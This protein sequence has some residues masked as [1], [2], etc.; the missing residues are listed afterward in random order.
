MVKQLRAHVGTL[1][2][3]HS[4]RIVPK[5]KERILDVYKKYAKSF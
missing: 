2:L 1:F 4:K 3:I 5:L